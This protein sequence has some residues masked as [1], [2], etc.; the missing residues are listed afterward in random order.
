MDNACSQEK[1]FCNILYFN[2]LQNITKSGLL[3]ISPFTALKDGVNYLGTIFYF[4][5]TLS[6]TLPLPGEG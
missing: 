1:G 4:H 5:S 2:K 6:N 3:C